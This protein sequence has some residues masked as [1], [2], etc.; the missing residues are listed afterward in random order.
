M[1]GLA[2]GLCGS[3]AFASGQT[4]IGL[5]FHP[6][7]AAFFR[8]IAQMHTVLVV[9]D[10]PTVVE[11]LTA[12]LLPLGVWIEGAYSA[13]EALNLLSA[14]PAVILAD[15]LMP[16]M[17]GDDFLIEAHKKHPEARLILLTGQAGADNVGKIINHAR[18]F[19]YI[20]KPWE[21]EDLRLTVREALRS[22]EQEKELAKRTQLT[23]ELVLFL[24]ELLACA[25]LSGLEALQASWAKRLFGAEGALVPSPSE[26][27]ASAHAIFERALQLRKAHLTLLEE[28]ERLVENR[29]AHLVAAMQELKALASQREAW[30]KIISHD[31]RGPLAG[32]RQIATLLQQN[33]SPENQKRYA[34][35]LE[36]SLSELE[37]YVKNL[38][39]LTRLS[40]K[41]IALSFERFS[42]REMAQ[43]LHALVAPSLE[44][45]DITWVE[46]VSDTQGWGD[47][48]Y[49]AE[50]LYN[51]VANAVKFTPAG[52]KVIFR[53]QAE[54][55]HDRV[56][57][58]DTG[59]GMEAEQVAGLWNPV[60]RRSRPGTAGEKGTGLG[61]PVAKAILDQH[62]VA[63]EVLSAPGTGTTF[64]LSWPRP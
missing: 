17:R 1:K 60:R 4:K 5:F 42:W 21:V 39:D 56:E 24:Q 25:D 43:R 31:L 59:I 47:P 36:K 49:A 34:T 6:K 57:I 55:T 12:Q 11:A 50:A 38:L 22:Y 10:E 28:L 58:Q 64:R 52:G 33:P 51:I 14:Q 23:Q 27:E 18:L 37:R 15:Y 20:A 48:V 61:L 8:N 32:L 26:A 7:A 16:G 63:V 30:I 46:E 62:G 2:P 44:M 45:K 53:V 35:L 54:D 40:H 3:W 29:T 19:R 9:D 41:E 13:E